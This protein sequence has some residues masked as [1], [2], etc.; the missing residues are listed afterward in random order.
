[1]Y[2]IITSDDSL[3]VG[4]RFP[5]HQLFSMR[6][7]AM[8]YDYSS[9]RTH[10]HQLYNHSGMDLLYQVQSLYFFKGQA[11][12]SFHSLSST[13]RKVTFSC[14]CGECDGIEWRKNNVPLPKS[15]Y[16]VVSLKKELWPFQSINLKH[17]TLSTS[18]DDRSHYSCYTVTSQDDVFK[19]SPAY[20][21]VPREYI[22]GFLMYWN[23]K[24]L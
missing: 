8:S 2:V 17:S 14:L 23:C 24:A 11:Y 6:L 19:N 18:Y 3:T 7:I 22:T 9:Q 10:Y 16:G 12:V 21:D 15:S 13:E 4:W 20:I 5:F 1:M